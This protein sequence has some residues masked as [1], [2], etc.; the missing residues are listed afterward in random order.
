MTSGTHAGFSSA[1]YD[2]QSQQLLC[3]L[4]G[5]REAF[6]MQASV[7]YGS[8]SI[9]PGPLPSVTCQ[10][11]LAF[12]HLR[13]KSCNCSQD[14]HARLL[15]FPQSFLRRDSARVPQLDVVLA[16]YPS[17]VGRLVRKSQIFQPS[18]DTV[19]LYVLLN[20]S[21]VHSVS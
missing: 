11:L 7:I 15:G 2:W 3:P 10:N 4:W 16:G 6:D 19:S 14:C 18:T 1:T 21:G 20:A 13:T 12:M 8:S 5:V 17:V 9:S